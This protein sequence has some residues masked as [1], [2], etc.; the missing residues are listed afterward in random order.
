MILWQKNC[1]IYLKIIKRNKIREKKI[2]NFR[3][4]LRLIETKFV[5]LTIIWWQ[6]YICFNEEINN[7]WFLLLAYNFFY[8]FYIFFKYFITKYIIS[9]VS[10]RFWKILIHCLQLYYT[11]AYCPVYISFIQNNYMLVY[12][13]DLVL[14]HTRT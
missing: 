1:F 3:I 4:F 2:R 12:M 14:F 8:I 7:F 13:N 6:I 5:K 10:L 9:R 11:V